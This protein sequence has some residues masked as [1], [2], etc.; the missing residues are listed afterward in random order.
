MKELRAVE[1]TCGDS[2]PMRCYVRDH[3]NALWLIGKTS[4]VASVGFW[5]RTMRSRVGRAGTIPTWF[6][7]GQEFP[8]TERKT[9][10]SETLREGLRMHRKSGLDVKSRPVNNDMNASIITE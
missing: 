7:A 9:G 10:N 6:G 3:V 2:F 5:I 8:T 4:D 1:P